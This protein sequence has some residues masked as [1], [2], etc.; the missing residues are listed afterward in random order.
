MRSKLVVG[1]GLVAFLG[2]AD[3]PGLA[4]QLP[5]QTEQVRQGW[6]V[7]NEKQ[8]NACHAIWGEGERIGPDLA[9]SRTVFLS[10]GQLAGVFWNHA[11]EMWTRMVS[12]GIPV[13]PISEAEMDS[14]FAFLYF[15]RFIDEPG[16]PL[17]GENLAHRKKCDACHATELGEKSVGPNFRSLGVEVNPILWIQDMWNHAPPMYQRMRSEGL[18]WPTFEGNEMVDLIA[19]VRSVAEKKVQTFL[20]PGDQKRGQQA[21]TNRG[22]AQCH[23]SNRGSRAPQLETLAR[24]PRTLGQMAGTMWN[25]APA[26]VELAR[27]TRVKWSTISAQDMADLITYFMSM[28]FYRQRGDAASGEKLFAQKKCSLCHSEGGPGRNFKQDKKG[29]TPVQMSQLMWSHWQEMLTKM[30]EMG[31]QWPTFDSYEMVDLL[32]YL[33][34]G[35]QEAGKNK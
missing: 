30:Q 26:M 27:S 19:Y 28:R 34:A 24:N 22:C 10:V 35:V 9:R 33:N 1:L 8:C 18:A 23:V 17:R 2:V 3:L 31:I 12:R 11:P 32:A 7:F 13:R 15:I 21:F 14:L 20:E 6:Q 29:V 25:H 16:D 5:S 4:A